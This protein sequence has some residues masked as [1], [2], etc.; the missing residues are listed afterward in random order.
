MPLK[1]K[2]TTHD[3]IRPRR[4]RRRGKRRSNVDLRP[5]WCI[6]PSGIVDFLGNVAT[7]VFSFEP[8]ERSPNYFISSALVAQW[9]GKYEDKGRGRSAQYV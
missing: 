1:L 8:F 7:V 3:E 6:R 4:I 5:Y 2:R 9:R